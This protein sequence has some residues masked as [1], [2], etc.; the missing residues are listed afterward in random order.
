[1]PRRAI[2]SLGVRARNLVCPYAWKLPSGTAGRLVY[3]RL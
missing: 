1:M 2:W 3:D